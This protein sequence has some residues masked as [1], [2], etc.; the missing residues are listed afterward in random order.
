MPHFGRNHDLHDSEGNAK[1][2]NIN[3][4]IMG[5]AMPPHLRLAE[6]SGLTCI[7]EAS[8]R[9]MQAHSYTPWDD[10]QFPAGK[11]RRY[12][13]THAL[14]LTAASILTA[15]GLQL[16]TACEVVNEQYQLVTRFLDVIAW[17]HPPAPLFIAR[18]GY[19][20][21]DCSLGGLREYPISNATD[22]SAD[23]I[24]A[25]MAR[26][27]A[28]R[29]GEESTHERI[30]SG[31][32]VTTVSLPEAYALLQRRAL[33]QGYRVQGREVSLLDGTQA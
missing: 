26:F 32:R 12:D 11:H 7:S 19:L 17:G 10:S 6:L 15:Q 23:S 18:I 3:S 24:T 27:L 22:G 9:H 33:A 29:I 14:C 2:E 16:G 30:I 25:A 20:A 28:H 8:I 1:L 5:A 31:P 21:E 4:R 13:S